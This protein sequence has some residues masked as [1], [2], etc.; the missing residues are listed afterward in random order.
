MRSQSPLSR[1]LF[2]LDLA[3]PALGLYLGTAI[4]QVLPYGTVLS[5]ASAHPSFLVYAMVVASWAAALLAHGVYEPEYV[6][7]W[8]Q[9]AT[10]IVTASLMA[11]VLLAGGIYLSGTELSRFQFGYT[12]IINLVLLLGVRA[13]ARAW[14]RLAGSRGQRSTVRILMIGAGALGGQAAT[15]LAEYGRWGYTLAGFLD[16]APGKAGRRIGD[17]PILGRIED[18]ER[19]VTEQRIDDVWIALPARAHDKVRNV[20]D[21]VAVLPVR[22]HI[23]PDFFPLALVSARPTNFGGLPVIALRDSV[24]TG[25]P[26]VVKRVFDLVV[27]ASVLTATAPLLAVLAVLVRLDSS[28][29]AIFRQE[30]VGENGRVFRMFKFRTMVAG[31]EVSEQHF[32]NE[33]KLS[34]INHKRPV[35]ERV[36]RVGR[37]LRRYSLDELPQ[38]YNVFRGEMSLVGPRPELPWLVAKYDP[39]QRGR[40]AVP[41]GMTGWWQVT[42]RS[43]RPM[44]LHTDED[45]YYVYNYTLWL[46]LQILA[47]TAKVVM[48]G[49]GAF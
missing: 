5:E 28:G 19:V 7:R 47:K 39:W 22:V 41:Q 27:S 17:L 8:Y 4:R 35:D 43:D 49:R 15:V 36:T 3:L 1:K 21:R 11:T 9:E 44:H 34:A 18:V 46:D 23:V 13:V 48:R 12:L 14:L 24:I 6:L 42:G 30:R 10:R 32:K 2:A 40:L 33:T 26:R 31:A 38:F 16:D 25:T 45:L 37:F 20:V 29:P